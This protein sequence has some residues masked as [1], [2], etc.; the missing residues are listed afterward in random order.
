MRPRLR[1]TGCRCAALWLDL[2]CELG[3]VDADIVV[4][5]ADIGDAQGLV[6]LEKIRVPGQDRDARL[7]GA[8]ERL[9]HGG[10]VGRRN[11]DAVDFLGDQ[12]IDDLDLLFTAAVLAGAD[13]QAF[14]RPVD[15]FSAFLQPSR[16]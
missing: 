4:V 2:L 12:V 9:A 5:G 6:L 3:E 8:F 7:L 15:S 13:I 10:S 11:G 16:A 14:D 1:P